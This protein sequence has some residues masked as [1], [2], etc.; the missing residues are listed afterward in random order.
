M[1]PG[2]FA[3]RFRFDDGPGN[4]TD[5]RTSVCVVVVTQTFVNKKKKK[6]PAVTD[7]E[8]YT[9]GAGARGGGETERVPEEEER[10]EE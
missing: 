7:G 6:Y 3:S 8:K 4:F 5:L 2:G 1:R 10:A 9:R